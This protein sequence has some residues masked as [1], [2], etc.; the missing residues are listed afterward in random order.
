MPLDTRYLHYCQ[1]GKPFYQP[2]DNAGSSPALGS[3]IVQLTEWT[4]TRSQPWT[5]YVPSDRRLPRQGWKIH[6]SATRSNRAAVLRAASEYCYRHDIPFK[7]LSTEA[8]FKSQNSKYANR[9][10]SGKFVTVYPESVEQF[11]KTLRDLDSTIG[12][13]EGPYILSD[14]RWGTGPIFYRYGAFV[15]SNS[16]TTFVTTLIAPDGTEVEDPREPAFTP[17]AWLDFPTFL[18]EQR[19]Q[20]GG[21]EFPFEMVKALHFSN[22]GGVYLARALTNEFVGAGTDVVLKEARPHTAVDDDG[23]DAV[24]RLAHEN[25]VL[26]DLASTGFVPQVHGIFRHWEHMFLVQEHVD[27]LDLKR[28]WMKRTP[29]LKPRPWTL[30]EPDYLK[31]LERTI[32][33][34]EAAIGAFHRKGWLIGDIHP[35]NIIMR[36]G[37]HPVFIDL[38]FA[39]AMDERWRSTNGAPGYEPSKGLTGAAADRWSLGIVELDLVLPQ[40][41]IADQGN[42]QKIVDLVAFGQEELG[43]PEA[44]AARIL[45]NTVEALPHSESARPTMPPLEID[46][47]QRRFATA[48]LSTIDLE[49]PLAPVPSD[50]EVFEEGGDE[51]R[52]GYPYGIV[53]VLAA[54]TVS[55][56]PLEDRLI[57]RSTGWIRERLS[58]IRSS[59]FKGREGIQYGLEQIGFHALAAEVER[60]DLAPPS[61]HTYW[62]GWAGVG[63]GAL[64]RDSVHAKEIE[65]ASD[66]LSR[67]LETDVET[68]VA[69]L[70]HGW[71]GPALFW[72]TAFRRHAQRPEYKDLAR[73]AIE[74]DLSACGETLNGTIELDEGWRTLPYLGTGSAGVALAIEE[75]N[76]ISESPRFTQ[77]LDK[78]RLASTYFQCGQ[79][80]FAHGLTG[81]IT[82]LARYPEMH[83]G[84]REVLESHMRSLQLHAVPFGEGLLIRGNQNLRLSCDFLTGSAGVLGGLSAVQGRW[85]VVPFLPGTDGSRMERR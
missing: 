17:P 48:I 82:M 79:G 20:A 84:A 33:R 22:G 42:H 4:V 52:I 80:G 31:W 16:E 9:A 50:I 85:S 76:A 25:R 59:G 21:P 5:V 29:V 56:V 19:D 12:H 35:K 11:E 69:G 28:E 46:Q 51:A 62:S 68:P 77:E 8:D 74:R 41:T 49:N 24:D 15:Q 61:D 32:G 10:S 73:R 27:G 34:L 13:L 66:A 78:L 1:A 3:D 60:L 55:G 38:E 39:H 72:T 63:L 57:R 14:R 58:Q 65:A 67:L 6:L 36:N 26:Q 75:L 47:L 37:A 54:L 70:L 23:L 71:S 45:R 83:S 44:A 81:F 64:S 7:H 40:A 2:A 18:S 43:V 30:Q 53:G